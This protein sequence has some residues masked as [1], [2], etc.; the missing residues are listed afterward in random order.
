MRQLALLIRITGLLAGLFFVLSSIA[1]IAGLIPHSNEMPSVSARV[2]SNL[3]PFCFGLV[4]LLPHRSFLV[5]PRFHFLLGAYTLFIGWAFYKAVM[6]FERIR[7]GTID[8]A[9]AE[10]ALLILGIPLLNAAVL[11]FHQRSH[12]PL[13]NLSKPNPVGGAA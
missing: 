7:A 5:S 1:D 6:T 10:A 2:M 12:A 11:W 9:A 13:N 4:L 3:K 8:P